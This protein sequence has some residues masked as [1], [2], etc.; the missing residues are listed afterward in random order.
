MAEAAR[1]RPDAKTHRLIDWIRDNL[2]PGLP[3]FGLPV[4]GEPPKWNDRRVLIF[5]ENRVGTK[6]FLKK[7]IESAIE[8]TDQADMRIEVIDGHTSGPRRKE[9]QHRF[10]EPP[11][12]DPLRILLATDAAREGLNFQA[13]CTDLFHFDLPWNPGRIEQRNGRID[14]KLQP[15]DEVRCHYF[16]L[17]QRHE[18]RVLEVL[19]RKTE[20]IR[21]ELGSLGKVI[22]ENIEKRLKGG[23][24]RGEAVALAAEL[25]S[26]DLNADRKR[27]VTDEFE[28][29]R[30]R[31][32]DLQR[33]IEQCRTL[34][35]R[36]RNW[37][38][39]RSEAFRRA[40]SC[41]L[42]I[43][44]ANPLRK[45]QDSRGRDVWRFPE[46]GGRVA[47]GSIVGRH[48]GHA[49][50]ADQARRETSGVAEKGTHSTCRFKDPGEL[51]EKSCTC[52]WNSGWH[53]ASWPVSARRG[54]FTT[55]S[56]AHA[57]LMWAT[58]YAALFFWDGCPY[59]ESVRNAC[60]RSLSRSR[61]VGL[62][63]TC[64][65]GRSSATLR[66]QNGGH[67]RFWT[68][69]S[70]R[71]VVPSPTR[72]FSAGFSVNDT[73][74]RRSAAA[75]GPQGGGAGRPCHT[76]VARARQARGQ[77]AACDLAPT[78]RPREGRTRKAR[79]RTRPVHI[80]SRR[81]GASAAGRQQA[82]LEE[83]ARPVGRDLKE[84]PE[85]IRDFYKVRA[86][87][88][89]PVGLVYLWPETG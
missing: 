26:M 46:L 70:K 49:T 21:S 69:F 87:R 56:R 31:Q 7:A 41:S 58:R 47:A 43:Q 84:E 13:H 89:E 86:T 51:T 34:L 16:K 12:K 39:F 45:A 1:I 25:E 64:G 82:L 32:R 10:N 15:A 5:T 65:R 60:T 17:P 71:G 22:D 3:P 18:D 72:S 4:V 30:D 48:P 9:V 33:Q 53:N 55:T 61:P 83:S 62:N 20:T 73:R 27:T 54:S 63:L 74:Y 37:V 75:A 14:R 19:V 80:G 28:A 36:S 78:E 76:E 66:K 68:R 2:C 81:R 52:T 23:I 85:R 50:G 44:Q 67:S 42:S 11:S 88:V 77:G 24:R 59:T 38:R 8:G 6:R 35:E 79:G 29:V 40:L 57:W